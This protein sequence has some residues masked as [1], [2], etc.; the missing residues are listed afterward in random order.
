[1][2]K[3]IWIVRLLWMDRLLRYS[4]AFWTLVFLN[5]LKANP[6]LPVQEIVNVFRYTYPDLEQVD[7]P[8]MGDAP[9]VEVARRA[10]NT[11]RS[12]IEDVDTAKQ[13]APEI[14][15]H[16]SVGLEGQDGKG[17][18]EVHHLDQD[19]GNARKI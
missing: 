3:K 13:I 12:E 6:G 18:E 11:G 1:M 16:L 19:L 15:S 7:V 5:Y 17:Q 2:K 10:Q 14:P 4:L 8:N 9:L